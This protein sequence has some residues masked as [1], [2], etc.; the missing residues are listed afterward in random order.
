[1]EHWRLQSVLLMLRLEWRAFNMNITTSNAALINQVLKDQ[2]C[3]KN[4]SCVGNMRPVGSRFND[5]KTCSV[6][7]CHKSR[8]MHH[9]TWNATLVNIY[10][11]KTRFLR[12]WVI[13]YHLFQIVGYY[14]HPSPFF[15]QK[16]FF[17]THIEVKRII[18]I[19]VW[20]RWEEVIASNNLELMI[21]INVPS[22]TLR[23][24]E[25]V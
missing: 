16:C 17:R 4:H 23:H 22:Q 5:N 3:F 21:I 10:V 24:A 2:I 12:D 8:S 1:M 13:Y 15:F 6:M 9:A 18:V 14:N 25:G 11:F 19:L 7:E 20:G